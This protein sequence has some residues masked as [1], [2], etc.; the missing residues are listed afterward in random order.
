MCDTWVALPNS[1]STHNLILGKNS[2][3]PFLIASPSCSIPV[4]HGRA[5]N[6]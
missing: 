6:T 2:D 3:R 1:T 5:A 4:K